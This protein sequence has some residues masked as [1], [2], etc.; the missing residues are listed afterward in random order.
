MVCILVSIRTDCHSFASYQQVIAEICRRMGQGM[1][2]FAA[3]K[4]VG[5]LKDWNLYCH[6]VAGLV[7]IGLCRMFA[8]SGLEGMHAYE[9]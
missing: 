3:A 7:G 2:D 1:A 9:I 6:Y 8:A 5:S 4:K